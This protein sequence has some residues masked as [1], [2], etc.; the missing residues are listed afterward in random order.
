[1]EKWSVNAHF[2]LTELG[3]GDKPQDPSMYLTI[4]VNLVIILLYSAQ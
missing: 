4:S 3:G 2:A 1:M